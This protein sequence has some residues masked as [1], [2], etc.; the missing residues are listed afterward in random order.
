M[1]LHSRRPCPPASCACSAWWRQCSTRK[2]WRPSSAAAS[3]SS[4]GDLPYELVIVDDGSSDATPAI[5]D[6]LAD[7]DPRIRVLHLSRP[8]GHQMAI[9]AGLDHARG[10]AVV[11][12]DGDLQ[13]PPE[14]IPELVETLARGRG[15][16]GRQAPPAQRRDPLQARHRALVLRDHGAARPG[17]ARPQRRR[18]P[19]HRPRAARRAAAAARALALPARDELVGR[20]LARGRGV[21][22][23]RPHAPA[24]RSTRCARCC[25]SRSTG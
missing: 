6:G 23:R 19:P 11:M 22:P 12:I 2:G 21:R 25:G 3:R 4:L 15:H 9:T 24:R 1:A 18:L 10:D 7:A 16:R 17:R 14:L 20:V 13:D 5:L 8:F